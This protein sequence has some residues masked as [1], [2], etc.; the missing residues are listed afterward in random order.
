M[1]EYDWTYGYEYGWGLIL[2]SVVV[3]LV[4]F[5]IKGWI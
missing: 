3:P 5:R 4:W 1:P 2:L